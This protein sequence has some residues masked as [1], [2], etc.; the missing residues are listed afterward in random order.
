[1]TSEG[2]FR[3]SAEQPEGEVVTLTLTADDA[4]T[5]ADVLERAPHDYLDW[6]AEIAQ[7]LR[8]AAAQIDATG[9]ASGVAVRSLSPAAGAI[10]LLAEA[11]AIVNDARSDVTAVMA[12]EGVRQPEVDARGRATAAAQ[13]AAETADVARMAAALATARTA[14]A[15]AATA[16]RAALSARTR[17]EDQAAAVADAA[18]AAVATTAAAVRPGDEPQAAE[19]ARE[20]AAEVVAAAAAVAE[21]T[22][23]EAAAVARAVVEAAER[24]ATPP[25]GKDV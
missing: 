4:R 15:V 1:M 17:A 21:E 16:A 12:L 5:L 20:K 11:T 10:A 19:A 14:D 23:I 3:Q 25:T 7:M 24:T 13:K 8:A 22:A 6:V 9:E 2:R 18:E